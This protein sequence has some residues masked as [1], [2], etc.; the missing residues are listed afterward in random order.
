MLA[1]ACDSEQRHIV[2]SVYQ[3]NLY[4]EYRSLLDE[5]LN[6]SANFA[7]RLVPDLYYVRRG[8]DGIIRSLEW[9]ETDAAQEIVSIVR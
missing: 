3:N 9:I 6:G 4:A 1:E 2:I 7:P 5:F 8:L